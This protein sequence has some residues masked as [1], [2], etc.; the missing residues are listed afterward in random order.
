MTRHHDAPTIHYWLPIVVWVA[1]IFSVS[2]VPGPTLEKVGFSVQDKLAHALVYAVLGFLVFRRQRFQLAWSGWRAAL[3]AVVAAA[4]VGAV[5]ETYQLFVPG[6]FS[7][8][9]DWAADVVG[10]TVAGLLAL[11]YYRWLSSGPASTGPETKGEA[12]G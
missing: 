4:V 10:G 6:R 3:A 12:S 1:A 11:I 7:S 9:A 5:D 2:S 8:R